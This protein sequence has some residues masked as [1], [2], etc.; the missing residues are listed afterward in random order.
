MLAGSFNSMVSFRVLRRVGGGNV[1][2]LFSFRRKTW[3]CF[4]PMCIVTKQNKKQQH[5]ARLM[6]LQVFPK[7]QQPTLKPSLS[8]PRDAP[9]CRSKPRVDRIRLQIF[10][11][12]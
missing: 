8:P 3:F 11:E 2:A 1:I 4:Y 7:R 10:T 12:K 6:L 5:A 9:S